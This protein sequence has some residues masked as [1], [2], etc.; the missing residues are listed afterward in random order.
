MAKLRLHLDADASN[1]A[2]HNA[3]TSRGHDVTRTPNPWMPQDANDEAQLL[4]ATAQGRCIFTFNIRDFMPLAG[5]FPA[6]GGII[7]ATQNWLLSDLIDSLDRALTE[8]EADEW[9]GQ[10]RWLS[11]WRT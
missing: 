5:K 1:K 2:L 10:L 11:N 9:I 8:T 3:L 4:G 6:H 7:L